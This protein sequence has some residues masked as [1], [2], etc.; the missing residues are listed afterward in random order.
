MAFVCGGLGRP[1]W[2]LTV[3]VLPVVL[4][5]FHGELFTVWPRLRPPRRVLAAEAPVDVLDWV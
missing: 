5:A 1:A 2:G 3:G 4:L